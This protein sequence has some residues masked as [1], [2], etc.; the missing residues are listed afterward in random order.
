MGKSLEKELVYELAKLKYELGISV[1]LCGT[2][3]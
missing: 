1:A 3:V 2:S